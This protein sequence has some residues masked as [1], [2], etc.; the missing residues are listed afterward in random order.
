[1]LNSIQEIGKPIQGYEDLYEISNF[2]RVSNYRKVLKTYKINS[3][4]EAIKLRKE[5]VPTSFLLHRLVA[6]H[7]VPNPAN[8]PEVNHI[9]GNKGHNQSSNL[10][11]VTRSE[12][13]SHARNTGLWAYNAPG[14]GVKKTQTKSL[15]FNVRWDQS[16]QKWIGAVSVG[17]KP[18]GAKRFASEIEA[19]KHVNN[20][21][22]ELG[23]T[24]R[25]R[26]PV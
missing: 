14:T 18:Y 22:D 8:K 13:L 6:E 3:G 7:F 12:N 25:P 17:N 16:R 24:D 19:A 15:Y 2:G 20:L 23:F 5:G 9:D 4:Y 26:N 10:E 1:M 11:W 21:L